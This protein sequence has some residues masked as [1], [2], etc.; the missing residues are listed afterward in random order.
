MKIYFDNAA[1][2]K[3]LSE[4]SAKISIFLRNNYGNPQSPHLF[5]VKARD[6]VEHARKTIALHLKT[7]SENLVFT[8]GGTEANNLAIR[9]VAQANKGKHI[10]TSK[11]EHSCVLESCRL[12][13]KE[14]Y[15]I[16]YLDVDKNGVIDFD[17][18]KKSITKN[19]V[20]VSI[21][22]VNNVVG[23][24]QPIKK[25]YQLCKKNKVNFH[26]D[27]VQSFGK[28]KI[29]KDDA[30]LISISSHKIHGPKG[31]GAL[32]I[33]PKVKLSPIL[34]GGEQEF[35]LRAGTVNA[36]GIV[37]FGRA[38]ELLSHKHFHKVKSLSEYLKDKLLKIDG[39]DLISP[40][41][42]LANI[43]N[44]SFGV[45]ALE[46]AQHLSIKGIA[47]SLGAACS[48]HEVKPSHV[49]LAMNVDKPKNSIRISISY[50]NTKKEV[51]FFCKTVSKVVADMRKLV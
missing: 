51:D 35:N 32:Y 21:M 30:D 17:Q 6:E 50:T 49:L 48:S 22:H 26:T 23:S 15:T 38:A 14:G 3:P 45:S 2:T 19:T 29:T 12:L 7:R 18:L 13:E 5:G 40:R 44:V 16:T 41:S 33:S 10:I 42:H 31:T 34:V 1:S 47:V 43:I 37:G 24:V 4:V 28:L 9:G 8:S 46:L 27:A 20:L 25:I 36:P 11:I 39:A